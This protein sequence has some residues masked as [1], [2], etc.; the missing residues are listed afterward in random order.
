LQRTNR[1]GAY[2]QRFN[3]TWVRREIFWRGAAHKHA[4]FFKI[5]RRLFNRAKHGP[6]VAQRSNAHKKKKTASLRRRSGREQIPD[7]SKDKVGL[8]LSSFAVV[9]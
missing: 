2:S 8:I 5:V 3:E 7:R 4:D 9:E 1:G 6:R